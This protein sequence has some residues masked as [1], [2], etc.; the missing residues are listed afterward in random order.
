MLFDDEDWTGSEEIEPYPTGP[1]PEQRCGLTFQ[2]QIEL[3]YSLV[4]DRKDGSAGSR[5]RPDGFLFAWPLYRTFRDECVAPPPIWGKRCSRLDEFDQAWI[6]EEDLHD[7][8]D[9]C[10]GELIVL[11][12]PDIA[13]SMVG[14]MQERLQRYEPSGAM[15]RYFAGV[16]MSH[17][18]DLD[19][20]DKVWTPDLP[21]T[22][23]P[24]VNPNH[25]RRLLRADVLS[26]K[27]WRSRLE[28]DLYKFRNFQDWIQGLVAVGKLCNRKDSA[29]LTI[30]EAEDV[31]LP[32]REFEE[33]ALSVL[34]EVIDCQLSEKA[35]AACMSYVG[36]CE[37]LCV[38]ISLAARHGRQDLVLDGLKTLQNLPLNHRPR[39]A[40]YTVKRFR[41]VLIES[42][43]LLG[44]CTGAWRAL[45][46]A[47]EGQ[48]FLEKL[49]WTRSSVEEGVQRFKESI[50]RRL[51][52]MRNR[53]VPTD[54]EPYRG[55]SVD[56]LIAELERLCPDVAT[57]TAASPESAPE[58][59]QAVAESYPMLPADFLRFYALRPHGLPAILYEEAQP[60]TYIAERLVSWAVEAA[61]IGVLPFEGVV[62]DRLSEHHAMCQGIPWLWGCVYTHGVEDVV[63]FTRDKTIGKWFM[64]A[65]LLPPS[66]YA[67]M[68]RTNGLAPADPDDWVVFE[69]FKIF[70]G[71]TEWLQHMVTKVRRIAKANSA[72]GHGDEAAAPVL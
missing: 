31:L 55:F 69:D 23:E 42:I 56:Q 8:V 54:K 6:R 2:Q 32:P 5:I 63:R 53:D 22:E 72:S 60:A 66:F 17:Q 27:P 25:L 19:E 49:G 44:G 52:R 61:Y 47:E 34:G 12:F 29:Y 26:G 68:R 16:S 67:S 71:F 57:E 43:E 30:A 18:D 1:T 4:R 65:F 38:G 36:P 37:G 41:C 3:E 48:G 11:G 9:K 70:L 50:D 45:P 28:V 7:Q 21:T 13:K 33:L 35:T 46:L 39:C 15:Q 51:E 59:P 64:H 40:C 20:R 62:I 24:V 58:I 14:L 10:L